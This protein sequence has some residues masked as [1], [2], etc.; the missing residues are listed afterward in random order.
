MLRLCVLWSGLCVHVTT[1]LPVNTEEHVLVCSRDCNTSVRGHPVFND[2]SNRYVQLT[3]PQHRPDDSPSTLNDT[4]IKFMETFSR[5]YPIGSRLF[6]ERY[7]TFLKSLQRQ[8]HL[9]SFAQDT[10]DAYYGI[11]QFS[12]LSVE[13]FTY[14]YLKS[15]PT[16]GQ[17]Y[18]LLNET[19]PREN[20]LPL[21]FDWRDKNFVTQVKNQ[22]ACGACWAFSIVGAIE[23][24]YAIAGH[25]LEDLSVQQVIDCS[26]LDSGC[27]GG[28]TSSAL[29]WIYQSQTK[30]VR[31]SEYPFKAK[32]GLCHF[33]PRTE[34]GVSIKGYEAFDF[35]HCEEEMMDM[36][37]NAGPLA[38]IVDAISWQDYLGGIIQHHCSS[39]HSN[40]AVLLVGFD[41][42]GDI[43]YWIVKNS[44]G[45]SWGIDGYVHIK[46]GGNLC[47][48]ADFV[49]VPVM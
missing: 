11:N 17:I 22:L 23:S 28:S 32:T 7:K 19:S 45:V 38:V 5:K 18:L 46:M 33:F 39:G 4:F 12:D 21:R 29:K 15:Y 3:V 26:Y 27:N 36:L 2:S 14:T 31:S 34:F 44:W 9:N 35:S 6:E 49:T 8:K 25:P 13:E 43:P 48:I 16:V 47:G 37:I 40:H 41:K 24:A 30:L 1:S 42:T 20:P 10:R